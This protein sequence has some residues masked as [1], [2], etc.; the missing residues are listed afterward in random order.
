MLPST[1]DDAV[2]TFTKLLAD[3]SR[4]NSAVAAALVDPKLPRLFILLHDI[5]S[6]P[7]P[8]AVKRCAF[9]VR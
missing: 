8:E 1:V 9:Q 5:R 3:S 4:G 7:S 2:G 6:D